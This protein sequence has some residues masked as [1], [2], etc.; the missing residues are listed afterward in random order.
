[1]FENMVYF[2]LIALIVFGVIEAATAGLTSVWFAAGALCAMITAALG[3]GY[4]LQIVVF[5]VI[6]GVSIILLRP[7]TRNYLHGKKVR[8]NADR[9]L[10]QVGVVREE[11]DNLAAKGQV[12]V[13]GV[14]WTARSATGETIPAGQNVE[15]LQI[16][17]VKLIV[18]S[19]Q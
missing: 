18:K 11:I 2:W 17:G 14:V 13:G 6:S 3:G 10:G 9:V 8:T 4:V 19:A 16:D 12:Q 5:I 1:M 7:L 15:V